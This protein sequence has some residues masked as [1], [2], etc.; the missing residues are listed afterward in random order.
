MSQYHCISCVHRK[1]GKRSLHNIL[2]FRLKE[3]IGRNSNKSPSRVHQVRLLCPPV[4]PGAYKTPLDLRCRVSVRTALSRPAGTVF[5]RTIAA[6]GQPIEGIGL[7]DWSIFS[8][9]ILDSSKEFKFCPA[10]PR[11]KLRFMNDIPRHLADRILGY[12]Q[13]ISVRAPA[14]HACLT[15][16]LPP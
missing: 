15:R 11:T 3:R 14:V 8:R 6:R 7:E 10:K 9:S 12:S 5:E 4:S 16:R 2:H 13:Q 1:A